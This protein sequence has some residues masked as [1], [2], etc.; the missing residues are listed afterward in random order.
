METTQQ[1]NEPLIKAP[2]FG[3]PWREQT[4]SFMPGTIEDRDGKVVN[5]RG[6]KLRAID[7]VAA[8]AGMADP[9]REIQAMRDAIK[10]AYTIIKRYSESAISPTAQCMCPECL[11]IEAFDEKHKDTCSIGNAFAKL[12]PFLPKP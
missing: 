1:A 2:D 7:C 8:C 12:Q 10:E 5:T 11:R 9:A 4:I 6:Q 3:E